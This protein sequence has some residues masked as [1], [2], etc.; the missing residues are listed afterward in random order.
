MMAAEAEIGKWE[1]FGVAL[2]KMSLLF[3][4]GPRTDRC[5]WSYVI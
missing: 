2:G 4:G 3:Q 1:F 5:T